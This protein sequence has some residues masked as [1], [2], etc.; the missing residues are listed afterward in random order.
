MKHPNNGLP[1]WSVFIIVC[2]RVCVCARA[3]PDPY[4]ESFE[5]SGDGKGLGLL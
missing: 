3:F 4:W 1:P 2:V 5:G